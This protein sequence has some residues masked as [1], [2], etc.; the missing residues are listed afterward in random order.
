MIANEAHLHLILNHF[1]ILGT[2]FGLAILV[3]GVVKRDRSLEVAGLVTLLLMALVTPAVFLSG[4]AAEELVERIPDVSEA[5]VEEHEEVAKVALALMSVTGILS[6]IALLGRGLYGKLRLPVLVL[7]TI[8][9]GVMVLTANYG[10][11]IR[12]TE[13]RGDLPPAYEVEE[14]EEEE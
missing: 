10:G 9:L 5:Y 7:S 1:P 8:T 4:E 14:H 2:L 11:K 12:H 3:A 6:F 13:I